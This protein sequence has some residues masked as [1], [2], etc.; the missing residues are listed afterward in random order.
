MKSDTLYHLQ[1]LLDKIKWIDKK[2]LKVDIHIGR[3][4]H[5]INRSGLAILP[6]VLASE[7]TGNLAVTVDECVSVHH[8]YQFTD[9]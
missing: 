4:Y 6:P 5:V 8:S 7:D 1:E 2:I 9:L 3:I